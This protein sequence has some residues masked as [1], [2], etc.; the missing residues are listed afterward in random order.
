V[1]RLGE[2]DDVIIGLREGFSYSNVSNCLA[3]LMNV[4]TLDDVPDTLRCIDSSKFLEA[5]HQHH[6]CF[7]N[8]EE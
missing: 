4:K 6:G 8:V 3:A 1:F 2:M 7:G 5:S